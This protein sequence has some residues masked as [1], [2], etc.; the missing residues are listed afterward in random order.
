MEA[1]LVLEVDAR[2]HVFPSGADLES[3]VVATKDVANIAY[4]RVTSGIDGEFTVVTQGLVEG[5]A[6]FVPVRL[7]QLGK[8]ARWTT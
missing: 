8:G 4:P 2:E 6:Q 5:P 7:V 1:V 3:I